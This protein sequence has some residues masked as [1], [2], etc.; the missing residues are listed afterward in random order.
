M[1]TKKRKRRTFTAEEKAEAIRRHVMGKEAVSVL[2]ESLAIAPNQ[3][4]KWQAELFEHA[5]RA[6][7]GVS[8]QSAKT[9]QRRMKKTV[10][11]LEEEVQRK[12]MVIASVAEECVTLKKKLGLR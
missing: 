1:S 4:Y 12:E 2:C 11:S 5:H 10:E 9:E 8:D 6:F 7:E 3:F